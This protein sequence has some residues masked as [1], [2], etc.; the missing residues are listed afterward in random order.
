MNKEFREVL[1]SFHKSLLEYQARVFEKQ[2]ERSLSPFD[3]W[4]LSSNHPT[5]SWLRK[6][7]EVIVLLDE[8]LEKEET[9]E[10]FK[11][12]INSELKLL[13]DVSQDGDFQVRLRKSLENKPEL[14]FELS[15]LRSF[16]Q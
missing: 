1:A 13:T 9:S 2:E 14:Q 15:R 4:H 10:T 7:S 12:W 11:K 5:F 6:I 3:L 16:I 8:N